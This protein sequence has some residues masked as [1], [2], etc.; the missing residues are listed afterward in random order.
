[1]ASQP[2]AKIT[3]NPEMPLVEGN[4]IA[5]AICVPKPHATKIQSWPQMNHN[6]GG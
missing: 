3:T 2:V 5:D 1:M 6:L 4:V